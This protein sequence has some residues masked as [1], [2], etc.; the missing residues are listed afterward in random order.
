MTV[1]IAMAG[2]FIADNKLFTSMAFGTMLVVACAMVGSL[3]VLPAALSKLGDR[4]DWGRIPY[5][6][7]RKQAAGESHFWGW[8]LDRVFHRPV[9]SIVLFGGL[10]VAA[11]LPLLGMH[12]KLPSFTDMPKELPIV[13]T[14]KAV[15]TAFPGAPTPAD[16][17]VQAPNVRST[18]VAAQIQT[19]RA[20]CTC[21]GPDVRA[22]DDDRQP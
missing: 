17:V 6:G 10:L 1:L 16:V 12:T 20:S 18:E 3:T 14:Y 4:V 13:Q 15:I 5:V 8:V 21:H 19:P 9:V 7:R 2:M 11:A 22:D